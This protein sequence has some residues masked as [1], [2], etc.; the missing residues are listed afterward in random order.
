MLGTMLG[1]ARMGSSDTARGTAQTRRSLASNRVSVD[2]LAVSATSFASPP[3]GKSLAL[4]AAV[5]RMSGAHARS[6]MSSI[7]AYA[8]VFGGMVHLFSYGTLQQDSVQRSSFGRLLKGHADATARLEA[9]DDR[10]YRSRSAGQKRLALSSRLSCPAP[11]SDEVEGMVVRRSPRTNSPSADRYEV[12]DYKRVAAR[13][14]SGIEAW[15]YV[16]K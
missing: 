9:R 14:K 5:K 8:I 10:D 16:R 15:V 3:I 7:S 11:P 12:A 6:S 4:D 13:L 1:T 2:K